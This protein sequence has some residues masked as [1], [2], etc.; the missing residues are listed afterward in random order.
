MRNALINALL[1]GFYLGTSAAF[2]LV[3]LLSR[4]PDEA[5]LYWAL[6]AGLFLALAMFWGRPA[7]RENPGAERSDE[8]RAR[9]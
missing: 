6:V 8:E 1:I 3:V 7:R 2:V 4:L 9:D 5:I